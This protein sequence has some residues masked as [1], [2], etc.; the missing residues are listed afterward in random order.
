MRI[1]R[2]P[3][4]F[5]KIKSEL[6]TVVWSSQSSG[7][8]HFFFKLSPPHPRGRNLKPKMQELVQRVR[9]SSHS[10]GPVLGHWIGGG[11]STSKWD[12]TKV[13]PRLHIESSKIESSEEWRRGDLAKVD[14]AFDR[15]ERNG[16][17][18]DGDV[19]RS[20]YIYILI[21]F[22]QVSIGFHENFTNVYRIP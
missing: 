5:R 2:S 19:D 18:C 14:P 13:D 17:S 7:T 21:G 22:H 4:I 1:Q 11:R 20:I 12:S 9:L 3:S 15:Y 10:S 16:F 8:S 6:T